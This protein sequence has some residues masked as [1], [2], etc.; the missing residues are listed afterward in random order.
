MLAFSELDRSTWPSQWFSL[1]QAQDGAV[2]RDLISKWLA[3]RRAKDGLTRWAQKHSPEGLAAI[4][5]QAAAQRAQA[6]HGAVLQ[7]DGRYLCPHAGC[8]Q[9]MFLR[10]LRLHVGPCGNL[11]ED[12]RRQRATN[13]RHR[14]GAPTSTL[15][16]SRSSRLPGMPSSSTQRLSPCYR[17][18][19]CLQLMRGRLGCLDSGSEPNSLPVWL[20]SLIV[21]GRGHGKLHGIDI[22]DQR[23]LCRRAAT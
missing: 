4:R 19:L 17:H 14:A 13:R 11:S 15:S 2:W 23:C 8:G 12:M 10:T 9:V 22:I 5:R 18:H 16:S 3:A 7:E 20:M 1:A 21:G 6:A